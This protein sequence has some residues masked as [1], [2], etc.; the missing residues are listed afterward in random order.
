M[1]RFKQWTAVVVVTLLAGLVVA[2]E[3]QTQGH[4]HGMGHRHHHAHDAQQPHG[5]HDHVLDEHGEP[6]HGNEVV[7]GLRQGGPGMQRM[8][9][10]TDTSAAEERELALLFANHQQISREVILLP[11][12]IETVTEAAHPEL[13]AVVVSHV[14]GMIQRADEDRDPGVAIQSPT[15]DILFA[16]RDTITTHFEPTPNGIRVVQTST[17]PATAKALQ[18]HAAEVT[19]MVNRGMQAIH[20]PI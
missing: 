13:A 6:L 2:H 18:T 4:Q 8:L 15:L 17:D 11:N 12:G 1:K 3:R 20:R 19:D 7:N 14:I 10:G 5:D 9:Q 16:N